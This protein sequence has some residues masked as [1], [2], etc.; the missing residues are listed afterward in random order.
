MKGMSY[1][2]FAILA[3]SLLFLLFITPLEV[4]PDET[5][6]D[7]QTVQT[8]NTLETSLNNSLGQHLAQEINDELS[9]F[10][11]EST[12]PADNPEQEF[13][14]DL[15]VDSPGHDMDLQ[16]EL[17]IEDPPNVNQEVIGLKAGGEAEI[18]YTIADETAGIT[19]EREGLVSGSRPLEGVKDPLHDLN[20]EEAEIQY[21]G[22]DSPA[23]KI[24]EGGSNSGDIAHGEAVLRPESTDGDK[25]AF[26][27]DANDPEV[28]LE[29]F[30][31]VV[32]EEGDA[33]EVWISD[34]PDID[35]AYNGMNA[36]INEEE[37]YRSIFRRMIDEDCFVESPEAPN[38]FTR[39]EDESGPDSDGIMTFLDETGSAVNE[40]YIEL[41]DGSSE[42][43]VKVK[44]V[45]EVDEGEERDFMVESSNLE[46][47]SLE[48][49]EVE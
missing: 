4:Q 36:I 14:D 18:G 45:S 39:M 19:Y 46:A 34:F 12:L 21:C 7:V 37:V 31:A 22:M 16:Q 20:G 11:E 48:S 38:I 30:R 47:W 15:Q 17:E 6:Q 5:T 25:I 35:K 9:E 2:P 10:I 27:E 44:G 41:T 1:T 33:G 49:L 26:V 23:E 40:D 32:A 42:N 28:D 8:L 43:P 13:E 3:S 29:D 24:G